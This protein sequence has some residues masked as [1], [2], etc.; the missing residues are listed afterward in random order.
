MISEFQDLSDKITRL[1]ELTQSLR[2]ENANL[3]QANTLLLRE[4]V[5]YVERLMQATTRVQALLAQLPPEVASGEAADSPIPAP[6][7]HR[8]DDA[9]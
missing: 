4:N 2:R 9:A 8:E 6:P 7:L 3:R 1:A 5:G